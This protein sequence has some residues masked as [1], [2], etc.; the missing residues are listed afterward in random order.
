[1]HVAFHFQDSKMYFPS[2]VARR[3][4]ILSLAEEMKSLFEIEPF[5]LSYVS[6]DRTFRITLFLCPK[7]AIV[8]Y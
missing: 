1:M 7:G 6:C 5:A 4:E 8:E 3:F 2:M